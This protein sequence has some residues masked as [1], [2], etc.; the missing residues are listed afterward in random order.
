[1]QRSR[2]LAMLML[3]LASS[4]ATAEV[5]KWVDDQGA[6]HYGDRPP[7]TATDSRTMTLPP[8]P[9]RDA[10]HDQR[11]LKQ[12]RLLEAFDAERAERD[13]AA[14]ASA[15]A[16]RESTNKCQKARSDLARI[17]RAS[18]V[19]TTDESGTRRY[20]NDEEHREAI[21]QTRRWIDKNCH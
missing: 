5:Y 1:M 19:Y 3:I 21:T 9:T 18:I 6:V 20:M 13:E 10:D 16:R 2:L 11:S 17:E 12:Q 15:A 14:A 8:A 4:F 7:A